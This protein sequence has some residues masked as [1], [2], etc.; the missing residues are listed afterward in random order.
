MKFEIKQNILI[1]HLNYT[2]RGISNKN[3]IPIL[4]CIKFD[5]TD[6]GLYLSSTDNDIAIKT[7][8]H[9]SD[10]TSIERKGSIVISGRYI[11][12]IIRKLPNENI[13]I[14]ELVDSKISIS[15]KSSAFN[16]NCNLVS[17][18]PDIELE[19]S[20]NPIILKK[21][22]FKNLINQ[23]SFA[24]SNQESRPVLTG[25]NFKIY[26]DVLE[27]TATDSYRLSKKTIK[28]NEQINENLNIII[29]TKNLLELLKLL[30]D[31]EE[32]LKMYIFSNKIIFEFDTIKMM[33]KL[34][35]GTYPDTSKL[36]PTEF[37]LEMTI[38]LNSFFNSIDRASL[39]T[40]EADKNTIKLNSNGNEIIISS[41]IPEIGN[42]EEKLIV[43][44][45]NNEEI[46]IAFSSKFMMEALKSLNCEDVKILFNG[47][48]KPIII[49]NPESDDLVQ[50]ILPI[51]TY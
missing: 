19:E 46:K 7:F 39:L 11:Y 33:S 35:N 41:N 18:F 48:V 49:R 5:L 34:I 9:S 2:I 14:E 36:I 12:D 32:S 16:L 37:S 45:N 24:T 44:K 15:T 26:S 22:I 51:R 21:T 8:I 10:I 1:E 28:L 30:K 25:I 27:C 43:Q 29:P 6:D 20:T 4:N 31:D 42:V 40:N 38:K 17:D 3:V 47:E 13:I 23:T 50:L